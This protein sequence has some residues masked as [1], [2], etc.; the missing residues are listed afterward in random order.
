MVSR[1][2]LNNGYQKHLGSFNSEI[3]AFNAYKTSKGS[4]IKELA[5]KYK[6]QIDERAYQVLLDYQVEI[7][8]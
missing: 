3:E 6:H 7:D 1:V 8:D 5:E 2:S 4:Y